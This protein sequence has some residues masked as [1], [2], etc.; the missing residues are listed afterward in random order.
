MRIRHFKTTGR[1]LEQ[2]T[3]YNVVLSDLA[4]TF[5]HKPMSGCAQV[6]CNSLLTTSLLQVVNSLLQVDCQNLLST[7]L[8]QVVLT[9]CK[10]SAIDKLQQA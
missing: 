4:K 5:Y 3:L 1:S 6:A 8:L 2:V 7:G 9:S 10:K